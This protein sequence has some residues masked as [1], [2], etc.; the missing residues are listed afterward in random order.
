MIRVFIGYWLKCIVPQLS[1][2]GGQIRE[3]VCFKA[4]RL[5]NRL[6]HYP[7]FVHKSSE[8]GRNKTNNIPIEQV[9]KRYNDW[10]ADEKKKTPK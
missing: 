4:T 9:E 6:T 8:N 10:R 5:L 1:G 3:N 2:N 7:E